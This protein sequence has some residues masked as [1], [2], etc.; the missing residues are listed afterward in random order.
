MRSIRNGRLRGRPRRAVR[1]A[2]V[3]PTAH[4]ARLTAWSLETDVMWCKGRASASRAGSLG[5]V[6][7]SGIEAWKG[8]LGGLRRRWRKAHRTAV[9]EVWPGDIIRV[10][11]AGICGL[12]GDAQRAK[13]EVNRAD[14]NFQSTYY[15]PA[16]SAL[17][18]SRSRLQKR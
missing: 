13:T 3:C 8:R 12:L 18:R 7:D 17:I 6:R 4:C 14:C 10:E 5:A 15:L 2:R 1:C 9:C 16:P 11:R